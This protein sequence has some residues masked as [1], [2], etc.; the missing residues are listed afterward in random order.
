M[1]KSIPLVAFIAAFCCGPAGAQTRLS[2]FTSQSIYRAVLCDVGIWAREQR[3][4]ASDPT[5]GKGYVKIEFKEVL[6]KIT[7]LEVKALIFNVGGTR[8]TTDTN[9]YDSDGNANLHS[10]NAKACDRSRPD[11]GVLDC[12]RNQAPQFLDGRNIRCYRSLSATA[13]ANA[14]AKP[15]G[16][17][18]INLGPTGE[19][20]LTRTFTITFVA[21]APATPPKIQASQ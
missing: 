21:P 20:S 3:Y 1:L 5:R 19:Y 7:G 18:E 6:T 12:L 14:S 10:E 16:L 2:N 4:V 9:G 15:I 17:W 13:K 8:T 11:V